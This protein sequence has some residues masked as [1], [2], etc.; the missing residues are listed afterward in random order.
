[1][2]EKR[3]FIPP[4][5]MVVMAVVLWSI[6][7]LFIKI[8]TISGFEVNLGRCLF[9]ALTIALLTR[10]R[11]LKADRFT[12]FA[13]IFYVGALSFFAVANKYTT[14]ANAIF[15]QYTAPVYIL[16]FA[17]LVLKEK[18]RLADLVTVAVCIGGM[19][20]FFID[21]APG[22][23]LSPESQL[24]GN[25]LGLLSGVSLGG[26]ILLLRHPKARNQNP[27]SS[28]FYGNL[29]A[30][31]AMIPFIALAPSVWTP[32]DL[33][34]VVILGVFQIG[35]AYYLFTYGVAHGVRSLDA[36]I[37]G[38]IEPLLNPVWV[39]LVIGERPS[40]WAIVGG[41]TIIAAVI[42]HTLR[43]KGGVGSKQTG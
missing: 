13:A 14:A 25:I 15:L 21:A 38:F 10:F 42:L 32:M 24:T 23:G 17:P 27:A 18:F 4:V 1:M 43:R 28:V 8:T 22:T 2:N 30:I 11:A 26:Y 39:F 34:A 20:L 33:V 5:V 3:T 37:I 12:L 9:A 16:V 31:A 40:R 41:I 6:G 7:G 19:S 29:F 36:S 35:L